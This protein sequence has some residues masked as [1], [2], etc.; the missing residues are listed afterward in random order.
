MAKNTPSI[1][2]TSRDFSTIR[3]DLVEYARRYYPDTYKDFNEA[4]FGSLMLDT[5]AYVGDI[6]SFYLDYQANES[7]ADTA[8]E[9]NNVVMHAKQSGFRFQNAPSSF[10]TCTF[11]VLVPAL[12]TGIGPDTDY[13]PTLLKG[14][15][16]S[17]DSGALF[18]L[19][20]DLNFSDGSNEVVVARVNAETGAPTYFAI[21]AQG[22]VVSGELV[23]TIVTVGAFERFLK[24]EIQ[25]NNITE[26]VSV[27]DSEGNEY[28][29]VDYLSQNIIFK[30]ITNRT[31]NSSDTVPSLL[32][33]S[34][35]PRRFVVEQEQGATFLQFGYGSESELTT[36]S[37]V[38][39]SSVVLKQHGRSHVTDPAFDPT[40]LVSTSKFG[41][42]PA[43]TSL[44]IV[45][46][47]NTEENVNAGVGAIK[48][49]VT[50]LMAFNDSLDAVNQRQDL[51]NFVL[52][53]LEVNNEEKIVGDISLPSTEEI[54]IL[55]KDAFA[56]QNRAVTKQDYVNAVYSMP[57][58]F[59]KIKRCAI[60][61]DDDS[62]KRN[63]NLYILSEDL[64]GNL[65]SANQAIKE[66]LRVWLN[67]VRMINDTI[68]IIDAKIIN[69]GVEFIV[70]GERKTNKFNILND[71]VLALID[72][73]KILKDV[74]ESFFVTDVFKAL[75]DVDGIVDVVDVKIVNKTGNSYSDI[76]YDIEDNTSA[77]GRVVRVPKNSIF[78]IR[79]PLVDLKGTVK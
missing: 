9:F 39:P 62:F 57:S 55:A 34:P 63:L 38:D 12:T 44:R 26:I 37:V 16:F 52:G 27:V 64:N 42:T 11:F 10:G 23:E 41:V 15:K 4:G 61:Q 24:L 46:R 60:M 17:A 75:R 33:A 5:V 6:L 20:E 14:S 58:K 70:V 51:V 56:A 13:I 49:V 40:K 19:T 8:V 54:K 79:F 77:D 47:Q 21:K 2:Y 35:A 71:A 22:Q 66:N 68:D 43:N 73:F 30:E 48:N 59:G 29:E 45:Y 65:V 3:N 31:E 50:P 1:K 32:K 78:E 36:D 18:T 25:G 69:I 28:F 76:N 67:N 53:T 7:F 74:G 72:E